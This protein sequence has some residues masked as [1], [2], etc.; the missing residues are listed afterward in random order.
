ME[1]I[2]K[3]LKSKANNEEWNPALRGSLRSAIA[4]RQ[5]PQARVYAAGWS[6]HSKCLFC[7]QRLAGAGTATARRLRIS[8][9]TKQEEVARRSKVG[10]KVVAT[11]EQ[12][13]QAPV[14]NLMHRLWKCPF[15][16]DERPQGQVGTTR[17][18]DDHPALQCRRAPSLGESPD[19]ETVEAHESC[20]PRS[21]VY[22]D[23]GAGR[24]HAG[25]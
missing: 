25:G 20:G 14:G 9:K 11:V 8:G 1:P 24:R 7:L 5:Y 15:V 19:A 6:D 2:T 3:L 4:G 21:I 12:I 23:G 22:M 16:W 13:A 10:H 17:Q 18:C